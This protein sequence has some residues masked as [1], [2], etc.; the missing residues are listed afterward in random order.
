MIRQAV[1]A[2][3]KKNHK[4]MLVKKS[5]C[6]SMNQSLV[7]HW[8]FPKG[9]IES[10][11]QTPEAAILRELRE[12]TGSSQYKIVKAFEKKLCFDFPKAHKYSKQETSMYLIEFLGKESDLRVD[13]KEIDQIGF[14]DIQAVKEKIKLPETKTFF[15]Q[16]IDW[17]DEEQ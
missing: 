3:V 5:L 15:F 9:G 2:I 1:G 6:V 11:D 8:D 13:G 17:L 10:R 14:Y 4:Y 16:Y 12:E 7:D